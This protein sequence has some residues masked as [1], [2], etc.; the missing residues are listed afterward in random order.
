M[1]R[2]ASYLT[3]GILAVLAVGL[4]MPTVWIGLPVKAWPALSLEKP[5]QAVDR[6]RK[7][8]RLIVPMSVI[9]KTPV[10]RKPPVEPAK[11]LVGCEPMFSPL[12]PVR[13]N[14]PGR[15]AA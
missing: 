6:S 10:V 15:C 3:V 1:R 11:I 12:S 5:L 14:I 8:D 9:G 4:T 13:A 2:V 7:S